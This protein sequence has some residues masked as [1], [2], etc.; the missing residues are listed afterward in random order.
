M[1]LAGLLACGM[2]DSARGMIENLVDLVRRFGMVPNGGRVYCRRRSQP[3]MLA[4]MVGQY[5]EKTRNRTFLAAVLP[6]L[7]QEHRFWVTLLFCQK[8]QH[9]E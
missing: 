9:S 2:A 8:A 6:T 7:V 5:F 3:P 4:L 1:M